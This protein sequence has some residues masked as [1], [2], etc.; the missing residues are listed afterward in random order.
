MLR[1]VTW[2]KRKSKE[3]KEWSWAPSLDSDRVRISK[4]QWLVTVFF[5]FYL[6]CQWISK[7]STCQKICSKFSKGPFL[8][9]QDF[10][11]N[12]KQRI[13]VVGQQSPFRVVGTL[14]GARDLPRPP[15]RIL[16]WLW[17]ELWTSRQYR[18]ACVRYCLWW[19]LYLLI[20]TFNKNTN[21]DFSSCLDGEDQRK[22][23]ISLTTNLM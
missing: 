23:L 4:H 7:T 22:N 6:T 12:V 17:C 18:T 13:I 14:F 10:V 9:T 15:D 21:I 16:E 11:W 8:R 5:V 20:L 19:V 3:I 2:T 1:N